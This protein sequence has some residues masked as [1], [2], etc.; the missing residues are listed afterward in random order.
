MKNQ[1]VNYT[2]AL[3]LKHLGFNEICLTYYF[4]DGFF[5]DAA[6]ED[7]TRYPGDDRFYK[8][9]NNENENISAPLKQQCFQFFRDKFKDQVNILNY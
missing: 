9:I 5:M 1:F 4:P 2:Q 7:D 6:E 8:H 3:A